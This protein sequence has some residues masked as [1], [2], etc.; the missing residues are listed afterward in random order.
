MGQQAPAIATDRRC[1]AGQVGL[2]FQ[3]PVR[4]A[5]AGQATYRGRALAA[6]KH[7][8]IP[9]ALR[10]SVRTTAFHVVKTGSIPVGRATLSLLQ[11]SA[12]PMTVKGLHDNL[13]R[14]VMLDERQIIS[15]T[16]AE[17]II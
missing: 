2:Y 16:I 11:L 13:P 15:P 7:G 9:R 4:L 10:L 5:K 17:A 12:W 14:V 3:L 8:R 1:R 6:A